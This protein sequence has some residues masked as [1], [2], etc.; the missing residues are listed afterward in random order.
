M[1]IFYTIIITAS[2]TRGSKFTKSFVKSSIWSG[3]QISLS[4][5]PMNS[6]WNNGNGRSIILWKKT[7][8]SI[9]LWWII[10]QFLITSILVCQHP[11]V[12]EQIVNIV[13]PY[14]QAEDFRA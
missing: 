12:F 13:I 7:D 4:S 6:V 5:I 11:I 1:V 8:S 9:G 14:F 10:F 3:I 2:V